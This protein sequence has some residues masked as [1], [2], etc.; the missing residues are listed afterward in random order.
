MEMQ[1]Q[2]S[3][4][5]LV[6]RARAGDDA[7]FAE[8][9]ER[10]SQLIYR[11]LYRRVGEVE[12]AQDLHAEVF[13]RMFEGLDRYEDRGWPLSA[14][15]YRIARSRIID[16]AR[17]S[18]AQQQVSLEDWESSVASDSDEIEQLVDRDEL[19]QLIGH[20]TAEQR[21]VIQLRFLADLSIEEVCTQIG[22]NTT[23]VKS[24]QYRA[25]QSLARMI[26]A[27]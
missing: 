3:D 15:L 4:I 10:Y 23:S 17:R 22:K 5:D 14:W 9:Y 19:F 2:P 1:P 6:M 11:Y 27:A 25:L 24:L 13:L 18:S 21:K 26:E 16:N 12:L 20:L 7:A 8:L